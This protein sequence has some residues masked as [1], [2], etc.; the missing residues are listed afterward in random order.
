MVQFRPCE[1]GDARSMNKGGLY[2]AARGV[3]Y[4][5][6]VMKL[7]VFPP[8]HS[9]H[10]GRSGSC[11]RRRRSARDSR[12]SSDSENHSLTTPATTAHT[13]PSTERSNSPPDDERS[14]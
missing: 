13:M 7:Q 9:S 5:S 2:H 3:Q 11:R 6:E 14:G 1:L 8:N 4:G 10:A 12:R